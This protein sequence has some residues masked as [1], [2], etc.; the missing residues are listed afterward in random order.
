MPE[1]SNALQGQ[2]HRWTFKDG[3]VA[4]STYEHVFESGGS[5]AFQKVEE[6]KA[7]GEPTRAKEYASFEVAPG[8]LL[9]SYLAEESGYTLT[10][11][12]NLNTG[13]LYGVAS[14][15]KQW[16]PSSGTVE[17]VK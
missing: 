10:V 3:P 7:E 1:T 12:L 2:T 5:V 9:V 6:G 4:G 15:D 16:F 11:A 14:N 17:V 13:R 8:I